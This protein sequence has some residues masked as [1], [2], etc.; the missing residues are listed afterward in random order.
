MFTRD[1][2][3]ESIDAIFRTRE[4]HLLPALRMWYRAT[5]TVF[6]YLPYTI[7]PAV[8]LP[9][10]Y[11]PARKPTN[12][13][14][15]FD[16]VDTLVQS[17]SSAPYFMTEHDWV[18]MYTTIPAYLRWLYTHGW[19]III[20][21]NQR[22]DTRKMEY[23]LGEMVRDMG[24][25]PLVW[26]STN[27]DEGAKPHPTMWESF[28]HVTGVTPAGCSFFVGDKGQMPVMDVPTTPAIY[29]IPSAPT[30]APSA[31]APTY[32]PSAAAPI[33]APSA[34]APTY[35]PSAA[36]PGKITSTA[37]GKRSYT[38]VTS[39]TAIPD[40]KTT[41]DCQSPLGNIKNLAAMPPAIRG[42]GTLNPL[43]STSATDSLFALRAGLRYYD[44]AS[45]FPAEPTFA[46]YLAGPELII[47]VGQPGAGKSTFSRWLN[48]YY[49]RYT[50]ITRK[51]KF[52][53]RI[54]QLLTAGNS[55]IFDA[56]NPS[57]KNRA[58]VIALGQHHNAYITIVWFARHGAIPNSLRTG[59]ERV[60]SIV[61]AK[62]T[63]DFT[64]PT[65]AE[66]VNRV[67]RVG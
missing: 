8:I 33:Y 1:C 3:I 29:N 25:E 14:A 21:T 39:A 9:T 32:V 55:V 66:G 40:E 50:I 63:K 49:P 27:K 6:Y 58:E 38:C 16:M 57:L 31:A 12:K 15:A 13:I 10:G 20:F 26:V 44:P 2:V 41:D 30:Y 67:V 22:S 60:P 51:D 34:A 37:E 64:I 45:A 48:S 18:W 11:I 47:T 17:A 24:F 28:L 19:T 65:A 36:A 7:D 23:I 5:P 62:Y 61:F 54:P 56:L 46:P 43:Y 59:K 42:Y 4:S 35:A 53:T 52:A